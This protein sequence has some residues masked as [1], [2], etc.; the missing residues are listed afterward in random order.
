MN[1]QLI[2]SNYA[3]KVSDIRLL[4]KHFG[5]E[6]YI[7]DVA[8]QKYIVKV[9]P[10]NCENVENE[11]LITEFLYRRGHKVARLFGGASALQRDIARVITAS[12]NL[13]E[14]AAISHHTADCK[15]LN[16]P[17]IE[18]QA[19]CHI[20][21]NA[22]NIIIYSQIPGMYDIASSDSAFIFFPEP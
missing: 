2:E 4:D 7:V 8:A 9:L 17:E 22:H 13:H 21:R 12:R 11:G 10:P 19:Y 6:I 1:S 14:T 18:L 20:R 3:L 16:L 5:T 15:V